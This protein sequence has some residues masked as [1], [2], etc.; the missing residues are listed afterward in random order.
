MNNE[1]LNAAHVE[2]LK[3]AKEQ[4]KKDGNRNIA[5][6]PFEGK[7]RALYQSLIERIGLSKEE[8]LQDCSLVKIK[9]AKA[10]LAVI[11]KIKTADKIKEEVKKRDEKISKRKEKLENDKKQ[12]YNDA[13]YLLTEKDFEV[14]KSKW[15]TITDRLGRTETDRYY[16]KWIA[17]FLILVAIGEA[18][19][20]FQ[21][22]SKFGDTT[23]GTW[24]MSGTFSIVFIY[25]AHMSGKGFRQK[26]GL[27][28][29][30]PLVLCLAAV[31][32]FPYLRE[33]IAE[34]NG[35]PEFQWEDIVFFL[36]GGG[37]LYFV[38]FGIGYT[39][40]DSSNEFQ[41]AKKTYLKHEKAYKNANVEVDHQK[42][43]YE[44]LCKQDIEEINES[45]KKAKYAIENSVMNKQN[46]IHNLEARH[47]DVL[48][49][50]KKLKDV[51]NQLYI[52]AV[53]TY[54]SEV[55]LYI[56]AST[57]IKSKIDNLK[58]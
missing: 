23:I 13:S 37:L 53:N 28:A 34:Y 43:G 49:Q 6:G 36:A 35:L 8:N 20:N 58:I 47:K 56:D 39:T 2:V 38:G 27:L 10:E 14:E 50:N 16:P 26:N 42:F 17:W 9:K 18:Y 1:A 41:V 19:L 52:E 33:F 12:A 24:I 54:R 40:N 46:E 3:E 25:A 57:K 15:E 45:F 44:K 4:G 30:I 31:V 55:E 29:G 21:V 51:C 7:L 5:L 11:K 32:S 48:L 22:F